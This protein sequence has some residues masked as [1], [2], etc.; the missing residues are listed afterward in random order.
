MQLLSMDNHQSWVELDLEEQR[1]AVAAERWRD[2][3]RWCDKQLESQKLSFR[4]RRIAIRMLIAEAFQRDREAALRKGASA[5]LISMLKNKWKV[6]L[7]Q[8][9]DDMHYQDNS[10]IVLKNLS[11]MCVFI[12]GSVCHEY[13]ENVTDRQRRVERQRDRILNLREQGQLF[14]DQ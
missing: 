13:G 2:H 3:V 1:N 11:C 10:A 7:D 4:N 9:M 5:D 14:S 12:S 8:I 6:V